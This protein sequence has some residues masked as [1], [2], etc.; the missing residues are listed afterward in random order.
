MQLQAFVD[1]PQL[2]CEHHHLAMAAVAASSLP[3]ISRTMQ[4]STKVAAMVA[5]VLHSASLKRV[6]CRSSSGWPNTLRSRT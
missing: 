5:L 1:D 4:S 6:F 2:R 3:S